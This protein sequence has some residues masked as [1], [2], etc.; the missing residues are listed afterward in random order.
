[1]VVLSDGLMILVEGFETGGALFCGGFAP[2]FP[3]EEPFL[4]LR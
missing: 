2:Y 4:P 3:F 1:V